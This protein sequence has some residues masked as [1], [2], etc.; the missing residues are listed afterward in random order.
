MTIPI[1]GPRH[2]VARLRSPD[3]GLAGL[4]VRFALVGGLGTTVYLLTTTVAADVVGLPF[5]AALAV[6]FLTAL[7]F[8]FVAHR[9]F[10]W[11]K[12]EGYVLPT[13]RQ[14]G[15]FLL[16]ALAQYGATA[17]ATLL[18]PSALEMPT[19]AVYLTMVALLSAVNFL[20]L[21][22]RV[23]HA[24]DTP[25]AEAATASGREPRLR[26]P[27]SRGASPRNTDDRNVSDFLTNSGA[28]D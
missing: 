5:Q 26:V 1:A 14:A 24:A 15:R 9:R 13:H 8:N 22:H 19:E 10:V 3:S 28:F 27:A 11:V 16:V 23:F 18:L 2:A 20:V 21:R 12:P 17:V 25:A 6:G 7:S 4:I